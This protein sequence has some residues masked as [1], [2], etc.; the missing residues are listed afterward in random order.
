MKT[1]LK[2]YVDS[3]NPILENKIFSEIECFSIANRLIYRRKEWENRSPKGNFFMSYGALTYLDTEQGVGPDPEY[4]QFRGKSKFTS[5]IYENKSN[6]FNKLLM[7]DF[8]WV[9]D[10]IWSYY[11][12][13]FDKTVVFQKALPGFHIFQ[14]PKQ[15]NHEL[16]RNL[17]TIHVDLPQTAHKWENDIIS[18]SSFTIAIELPKCTAGLNIWKDDSIF[19]NVN[20]VF[21]D[22]MS[23]EDQVKIT[24]TAEY[25]PYKLGYIYEQDGMLRHQITVGGDILE[26]ERRITLQGHLVETEKEIIIYV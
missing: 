16:V 20:T 6:Y 17:A 5:N 25:F 24:E 15:L 9:Y 8:Y 18:A 7:L 26:N 2:K 23:K 3:F 14:T 19:K 11:Q 22:N 10:K 21:Y 13:K 4:D 12:A 1:N